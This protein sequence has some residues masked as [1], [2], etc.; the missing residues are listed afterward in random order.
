MTVGPD[1][2]MAAIAVSTTCC[3]VCRPL[4]RNSSP[5]RAK[6]SVSVAPG[7]SANTRTPVDFVS[8]HSASVKDSTNA[9]VAP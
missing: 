6:N 3:E 2:S 7:H 9:L 1:L 5:V 4:V 8:C